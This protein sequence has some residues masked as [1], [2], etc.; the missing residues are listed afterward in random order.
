MSPA[1]FTLI[2]LRYFTETARAGS[3]TEAARKLHVSQPALSTAI[4][5]LERDLG[6]TLFERVPRKG[7]RLTAAGRQFH[8]DAVALLS[9]AESMS[10]RAGNFAGSLSGTLRVG[11]YLPMAPFRAPTVVHA[12]TR[13]HPQIALELVEAD[14]DELVRMLDEQEIDVALAYAMAPFEHHE[15]ELLETIQP[16]MIVSPEHPLAGARKPVSLRRFASDPLILL[17]LPHTASYYLGLIRSVGVEPQVRFRVKGYETVRGLVGRGFGVS[18]LNQRVAHDLTYGG[19]KVVAV[20]LEEELPGLSLRLVR[21]LG[22]E[23]QRVE[24][25]NEVC[26][27]LYAPSR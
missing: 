10:E 19:T 9:H 5:Q 26:R 20:E 24:A 23:S 1:N 13:R 12:F 17:D 11:M 8:L 22:E 15:A 18:L 6:A 14:H 16:H 3:M 7:I 4:N 25:F 21:R 2:Q 27:R